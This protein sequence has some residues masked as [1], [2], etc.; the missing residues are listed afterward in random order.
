MVRYA[1]GDRSIGGRWVYAGVEKVLIFG[2]RS[3]GPGVLADARRVPVGG[4]VPQKVG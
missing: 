2:K 3:G 4:E 1:L